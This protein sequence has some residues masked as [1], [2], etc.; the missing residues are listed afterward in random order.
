VIEQSTHDLFENTGFHG[1]G[2]EG[3]AMR[4]WA[5][6]HALGSAETPV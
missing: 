6:L 1:D 3:A 5:P 2:C 4:V